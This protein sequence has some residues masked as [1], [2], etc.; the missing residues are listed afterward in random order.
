M[1]MYSLAG[2]GLRSLMKLLLSQD[3]FD[4]FDLRQMTIISAV[5]FDVEGG[6]PG[7]AGDV[8]Y[9][10]WGLFRPHAYNIVKSFGKPRYMKVVLACPQESI[11]AGYKEAKALFMNIIYDKDIIHITTGAAMKSFTPDKAEEG[12]WDGYVYDFL[13]SNALNIQENEG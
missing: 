11:E 6:V 8:S 1:V 5:R 3:I 10:K 7:E 9:G 13:K 12:R 4:G 2:D